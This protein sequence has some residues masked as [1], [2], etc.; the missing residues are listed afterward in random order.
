MRYQYI[1]LAAYCLQPTAYQPTA[2][3]LPPSVFAPMIDR[4]FFFQ[5]HAVPPSGQS[6][7]RITV[8]EHSSTLIFAAA[9]MCCG[10]PAMVANPYYLTTFWLQATPATSQASQGSRF[11]SVY[12]TRS[13]SFSSFLFSY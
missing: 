8:V 4:R 12:W 10:V 2:Y 13:S 9:T 7:R 3:C 11:T 6:I 5:C 1:L